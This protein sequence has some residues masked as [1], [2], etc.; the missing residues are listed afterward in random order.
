MVSHSDSAKHHNLRKFKFL[1]VKQWTKAPSNIQHAHPRSITT[2]AETK[3]V[4]A[5]QC[6]AYALKEQKYVFKALLIIDA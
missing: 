2:S 6:D 5:F 1:I 4:K 3:R